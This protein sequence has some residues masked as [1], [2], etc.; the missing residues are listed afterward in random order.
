MLFSDSKPLIAGF[1]NDLE[2][3]WEAIPITGLQAQMDSRSQGRAPCITRTGARGGECMKER[4]QIGTQRM[5]ENHEASFGAGEYHQREDTDL[6]YETESGRGWEI[7]KQTG[8]PRVV[9]VKQAAIILGRTEKAVR[10]LWEKGKM[11]N[12]VRIDSRLQWDSRDILKLIQRAKS[13]YHEEN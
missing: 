10:R 9:G 4:A 1:R 3:R 11:P 13:P 12:P 2:S 5:P 7:D 8:F 6:L